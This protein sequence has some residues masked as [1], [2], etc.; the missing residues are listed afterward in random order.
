MRPHTVRDV[1][2]RLGYRMAEA[3]R[4][5]PSWTGGQSP[6]QVVVPRRVPHALV[7]RVR[8]R[9]AW[10]WDPDGIL[11]PGTELA[12]LDRSS[13]EVRGRLRTVDSRRGIVLEGSPGRWDLAGPPPWWD[14]ALTSL[15]TLLARLRP[16]RVVEAPIYSSSR[17]RGPLGPEG[18][19]ILVPAPHCGWRPLA[20]P[21]ARPVCPG[22]GVGEED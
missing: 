1:L 19:L 21:E 17:W 16:Y 15:E 6:L 8:G 13:L 20:A 4:G 12:I 22:G 10:L 11:Q 9:E 7:A 14:D 5:W 2:A 3:R 18:A